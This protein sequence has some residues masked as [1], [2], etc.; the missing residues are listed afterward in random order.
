MGPGDMAIHITQNVVR[1]LK[2][3]PRG[4]EV[5]WDDD[6]VGF[7]VR[8]TAAG[9]ISFVLRYVFNGLERRYTIGKYPDWSPGGA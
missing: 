2:P 8:I 9:A 1:G 7:G 4:N 3:P 6:V 5:K